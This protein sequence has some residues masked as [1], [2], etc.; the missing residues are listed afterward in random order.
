MNN[1]SS[2]FSSPASSST[3]SPISSI[4]HNVQSAHGSP[5][6]SVQP[7]LLAHLRPCPRPS[8]HRRSMREY[9]R[10]YHRRRRRLG[11]PSPA[12]AQAQAQ[13]QTAASWRD[14][15][16]ALQAA[17]AGQVEAER[18]WMATLERRRRRDCRR[19]R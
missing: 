7:L 1:S 15:A 13:A 12:Q 3:S 10:E 17:V 2:T 8:F 19:T 16:D 6:S 4:D 11:A 5:T 18:R 14:A 9:V